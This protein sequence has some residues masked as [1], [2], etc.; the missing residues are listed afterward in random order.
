MAFIYS[1][2]AILIINIPLQ[3]IVKSEDKKL[4]AAEGFVIVTLTWILLSFFG[5]L[6][7]YFSGQFQTLVDAFFEVSSGFTTTGA[8]VLS[9]VSHQTHSIIMWKALIQGV[10]GM[11][12]LVF[13]LAVL[14]TADKE[15]LHLMKAESPGPKFGKVVSKLKDSARILYIMY[16]AMLLVLT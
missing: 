3:F 13:A 14:P 9:D 12:V 5:G 10:G 7:L 11:G 4:Y 15:D 2:M 16:G 8:S 1:I 6:P